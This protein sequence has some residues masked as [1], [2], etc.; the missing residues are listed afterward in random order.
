MIKDYFSG[1][2][3][4][5]AGK[6]MERIREPEI[7]QYLLTTWKSKTKR[8]KMQLSVQQL[9]T[10]HRTRSKSLLQ[11]TG[12]IQIEEVKKEEENIFEGKMARNFLKVVKGKQRSDESLIEP[13]AKQIEDK[14]GHVHHRLAVNNQ[15]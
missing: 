11:V 9:R 12:K 7:E 6:L 5:D 4:K 1:I 14:Y 3:L 13:Q 15:V 2:S 10:S 8:K